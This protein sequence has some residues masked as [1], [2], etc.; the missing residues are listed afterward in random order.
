[1]QIIK[2]KELGGERPLF[3][4]RDLRLEHV[5]IT[6]GESA[7]K[8]CASVEASHCR[9][10]GRYP[11][12]H[13]QRFTIDHC[14]FDVDARSA[15]WY[16][17]YLLMRHTRID[18]PKMFREM[19]HLHLEDVVINDADETFWR[20]QYIEACNLELHG[21]TYPFMF[22]DFVRI[23]GLECDAKYVFQYCRNVE[24]HNAHIVTKDAFWECENVNIYDSVL[25]GEYLGWHSKNVRLVN[26]HL[27]G[28]QLLCYGDR[29]VLENCTF[30]AA[31]D[32]L[33]EYSTVNADVKGHIEN[34]KNPTS[35][36]IVADTIGSVTI[37]DNVLAP[38]NC[39]IET[40][41]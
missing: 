23:N 20:C 28:E 1:M 39:I 10:V 13:T 22:C 4:A 5:T 34:I 14:Q 11:F 2:D 40:R 7:L 3:A 15:L 21:G 19:N 26:C 29:L 31:C 32:R 8:H 25:D 17:N 18:A 6:D 38:N 37:D 30:D 33:F 24:L 41:Q 12:W 35:G 9:F 36:R 27:A 16:S